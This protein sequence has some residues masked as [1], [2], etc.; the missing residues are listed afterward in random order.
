MSPIYFSHAWGNVGPDLCWLGQQ[1]SGH[2][3][4]QEPSTVSPWVSR[5]RV[6]RARLLGFCFFSFFVSH[7]CTKTEQ[8]N[9]T[10]PTEQANS[11]ILTHFLYT[12]ESSGG[13]REA[14]LWSR[15]RSRLHVFGPCLAQACYVTGNTCC[16][17]AA[18]APSAYSPSWCLLPAQEL[19]QG[20]GEWRL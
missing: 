2:S 13:Q 14:C 15:R 7:Q 10:I 1:S 20:K 3:W 18:Q 9:M 11:Q 5:S 12:F 16:R 17:F 4:E 8:G 6:W 19:F